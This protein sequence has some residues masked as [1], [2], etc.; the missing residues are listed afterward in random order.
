MIS[1]IIPSYNS[2]KTIEKCLNS[3]LNQTYRD[4]YEIIVVDSSIDNTSDIVKNKFKDVKLV[5]LK[6]KTDPG[7]ARN[8]GIRLS[9]SNIIAFID[10]D[11]VADRNWLKKIAYSQRSHFGVV[12]G[13]V[14]NGNPKTDIIGL[15]GYLSEFRE[16]LPNTPK[17]E[18]PH[19]PTCN[20]SYKRK[21][22]ETYGM[23]PGK[24]YPQEDLVFNHKLVSSGEKILMDPDI[25]VYHHHRSNLKE[26]LQHQKKIG[27]VTSKVLKVIDLE[28]A[29]IARNKR[30]AIFIIPLLPFVKF[31][32]TIWVFI[33][34]QPNVILKHPTAL[35]I[36]LFGL[37]YWTTGFASGTFRDS[38]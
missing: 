13:V 16:F 6:K 3:I 2:N 30:I 37:L 14:F 4:K 5:H 10:S 15:A 28:G 36:F 33:K 11:C 27:T 18:V 34:R 9:K 8:I 25:K 1:V 17:K 12:G 29:F 26:F 31:S 22:F 20:I 7:T 21:I 24:Y 19:I 38:V 32:R 35:M 23:F